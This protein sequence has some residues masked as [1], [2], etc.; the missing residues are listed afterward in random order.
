MYLIRWRCL[1]IRRLPVICLSDE[2]VSHAFPQAYPQMPGQV[3]TELNGEE[4]QI[5]PCFRSCERS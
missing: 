1:T 2:G 5:A 3:T 4:K